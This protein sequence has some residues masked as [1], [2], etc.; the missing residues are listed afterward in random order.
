MKSVSETKP[1][2]IVG[3]SGH[4]REIH[5]VVDAINAVALTWDLLGYVDDDPSDRNR[6]LVLQRGSQV[7]G[8]SAWL[9]QVDPH[10]SYVLGVGSPVLKAGLDKRFA[11]RLSPILV[12]PHSSQGFDVRFGPGSV[13]FA[14]A[15]L[16]TN[17]RLGRHVHVNRCST[18][19]HDVVIADYATINP[20]VAVSGNVTIGNRVMLGTHSCIL[21]GLE[22]GSGSTVGGAALVTKNVPERAVVKGLPASTTAVVRDH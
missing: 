21:Q 14:G 10:I 22:V 1:L 13:I 9:D 3:C 12:H 17:I 7:L 20:L 5:D 2:V 11:D 19:G 16:T 15:Q 6:D 4:G 8:G 18:I